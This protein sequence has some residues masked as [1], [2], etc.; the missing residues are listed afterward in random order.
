MWQRLVHTGMYL[1]VPIALRL[2][3]LYCGIWR[4]M[5]V[6]SCQTNRKGVCLGQHFSG[7]DPMQLL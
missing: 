6:L 7:Y 4:Q 2:C 3:G 1:M 5:A